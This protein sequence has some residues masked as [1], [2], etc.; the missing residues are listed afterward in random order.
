[1]SPK[2]NFKS[3]MTAVATLAGLALVGLSACSSTGNADESE[4][5]TAAPEEATSTQSEQA[6][7]ET[8]DLSALLPEDIQD[9]GALRIG[10]SPNFPPGNFTED[11]GSLNGYEITLARALGPVLGTDIE[12]VETN[13]AGLLS[14]LQADRFDVILSGMNDTLEREEI[15]TFVN[16]MESGLIFLVPAGNEHDI[17][18]VE[19]V[20][21]LT[22][23]QTQG[24]SNYIELLEEYSGE[25]E[26]SGEAPISIDTYPAGTEVTQAVALNRADFSFAAESAN[27]YFALQ[28]DG[29]LEVVGE[30]IDPV[31]TGFAVP[32]GEDELVEALEA[33]LQEMIDSGQM[34]EL[35]AEWG[36]ES[37]VLD[38]VS[39]NGAT[40]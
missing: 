23:A 6:Q 7:E 31:M 22:A 4:D 3:R 26:A 19:D 30:P 21:G 8:E 32:D 38:Q 12:H 15:V 16:Y 33:G 35:M 18:T 13:F 10:V 29:A 5:P 37:Q 39:I 28:S 27:R 34:E 40:S 24:S 14:G 25:C 9:A 20:C 36:V 2:K 17:Q 11:D 1:M